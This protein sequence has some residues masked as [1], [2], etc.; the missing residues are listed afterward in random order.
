MKLM[1]SVDFISCTTDIWSV[2]QCTDSLV[3]A[4]GHWTDNNV[5]LSHHRKTVVIVKWNLDSGVH[6]FV[7]NNAT[8]MTNITITSFEKECRV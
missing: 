1:E 7:H 5:W 8:N 2:A 4:T 6:A 3:S